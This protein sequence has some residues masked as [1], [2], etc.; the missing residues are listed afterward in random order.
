MILPKRAYAD[1]KRSTTMATL[2]IKTLTV[3]INAP[4]E[5]VARDLADAKTHPE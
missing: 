5:Q 3:T 4:F 2:P 1:P